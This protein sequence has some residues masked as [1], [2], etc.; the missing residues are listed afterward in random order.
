MDLNDAYYFVHVVDKKGFS[1]AA[2]A[3]GIPK[4]RVSRRVK[5]LETT[6]G[7]RLMQR[8]SRQ[9]VLTEVGREYYQHAREAVSHMEAAET[10]VRR[11]MHAVEGVV[12]LSCSVGMAQFALSQVLPDF[13][14]ENPRVNVVQHASNRMVDL[15]DGGIDVAIRGH[16]DS[17]PDSSLIQT[18]LA[19]VEWHVFC[20]PA[21]LEGRDVL[22]T[23]EDLTDHPCLVLGAAQ[24]TVQWALQDV[25]GQQV[26]ATCNLRMASD[27]M[28]TLKAVARQGLGL[29][30]L[31][32][33]VCRSELESGSLVRVL[34]T[35]TAGRPQ[36]SLIMPSRHGVL[37]AVEAFVAHLKKRV[38][39]ALAADGT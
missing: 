23:P 38:P 19:R 11:K 33:Y 3:L 29:V 39:S 26:T 36:I 1:A 16:M 17:L 14:E 12:R 4:S 32:S 24:E 8:S 28:T 2:R 30:V 18:R 10:A 6:L 20:S 37:P 25:T 31:P 15:L 34:P 7:I 13:L 22:K 27:D 9:M 5:E 35:W 21:Y